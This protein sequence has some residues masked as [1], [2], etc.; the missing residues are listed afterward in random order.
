[1]STDKYGFTTIPADITWAE[2]FD[3]NLDIVEANLLTREMV[4]LGTEV[5]VYHAVCYYRATDR[6]HHARADGIHQP[7]VGLALEGGYK[8]SAIKIQ[9]EGPVE[10][11]AWNWTV[12]APLY[13][14]AGAYGELTEIRPYSDR[15]AVGYAITA[16]SVFLFGGRRVMNPT[17]GLTT[18]TTSTSTSTTSSMS[19]TSTL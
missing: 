6:Y 14:S 17:T 19:T 13:L 2:V 18:T 4:M 5:P 11:P 10:N 15:Q 12:G 3:E 7:M 9:R 1:M 8:G 16:T